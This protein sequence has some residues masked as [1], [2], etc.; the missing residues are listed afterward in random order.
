M[1]TSGRDRI[2]SGYL[3]V[4]HLLSDVNEMKFQTPSTQL[5]TISSFQNPNDLNEERNQVLN[6]DI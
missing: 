4:V 1:S 6:L 3:I 2:S 5:Q